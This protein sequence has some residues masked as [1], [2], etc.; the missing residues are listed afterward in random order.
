VGLRRETPD[1]ARS[2]KP[3]D[4]SQT[5]SNYV[6]EVTTIIFAWVILHEEITVF[7]VIGTF[8]ILLGMYLA[9][10]RKATP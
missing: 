1:A 5:A 7:F 4:A 6:L 8:L 2:L 9:D 10:R 3:F